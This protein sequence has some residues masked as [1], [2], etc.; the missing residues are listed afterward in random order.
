[1]VYVA[2]FDHHEEAFGRTCCQVLEARAGHRRQVEAVAGYGVDGVTNVPVGS[3][4]G[5][6][7][8]YP[9]TGIGERVESFA[10]AQGVPSGF[11]QTC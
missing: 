9:R 7:Q 11:G 5:I 8:Q 2:A 1:M 6:Q 10:S 3:A 4:V